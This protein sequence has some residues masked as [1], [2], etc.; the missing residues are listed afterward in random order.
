MADEARCS[1]PPLK[2]ARPFEQTF[3][4][5]RPGYCGDVKPPPGTH[6]KA[7]S[8]LGFTSKFRKQLIRRLNPIRP[9]P[10]TLMNPQIAFLGSLLLSGGAF[11]QAP[12][13]ATSPEENLPA[14]ITQM[15]WFGERADWSHDGKKILFLTKIFG[16]AM[17]LSPQA[18]SRTSWEACS[19][20]NPP[21]NLSH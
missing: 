4:K 5:S 12:A 2:S 17:K 18:I 21:P 16:D 8:P 3:Q 14:H 13:P 10:L 9:I 6:R 1:N 20:A 11:A 15:T 19:P 7:F